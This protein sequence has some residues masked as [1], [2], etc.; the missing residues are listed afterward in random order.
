MRLCICFFF[1]MSS[2]QLEPS[3]LAVDFR[4]S[5]CTLA[6]RS[7]FAFFFTSCQWLGLPSSFSASTRSSSIVSASTLETYQFCSIHKP[8]ITRINASFPST[9]AQSILSRTSSTLTLPTLT[10]WPLRRESQ[11][12]VDQ[13]CL[14][15]TT[16]RKCRNWES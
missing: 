9:L 14:D 5:Y 12:F 7:L 11:R 6:K 1:A 15:V 3:H 4:Q 16:K 10:A 2:Q 8:V 13:S